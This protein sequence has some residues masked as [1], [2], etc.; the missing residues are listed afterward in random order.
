M[1]RFDTNTGAEM[2]VSDYVTSGKYEWTVIS[3]YDQV[4]RPI[5]V[6]NGK[7][8]SFTDAVKLASEVYDQLINV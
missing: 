7:S 6:E 1:R 4:G 3:G 5:V 8:N 2:W